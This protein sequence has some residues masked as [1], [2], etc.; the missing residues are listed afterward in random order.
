MKRKIY[1]DD[2]GRF[3]CG[4]CGETFEN[5]GKVMTHIRDKHPKDEMRL[6]VS[7]GVSSEISSGLSSSSSS[8]INNIDERLGK[9]ER[10]VYNQVQHLMAINQQGV[11]GISWEALRWI[12]TGGIIGAMLMAFFGKC[13][14]VCEG[15]K[16]KGR[17]QGN[18]IMEKALGYATMQA[19][20]KIIK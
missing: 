20:K 7:S 14:C 17:Y 8:S 10:T 6:K 11:L 19:V 1:I 15:E 18:K 13:E 4:I 16:K 2:D 9:L 3:T 5:R 12:I